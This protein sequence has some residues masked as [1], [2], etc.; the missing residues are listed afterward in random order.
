MLCNHL[1]FCK[2]VCKIEIFRFVQLRAA[3]LS[4]PFSLLLIFLKLRNPFLYLGLQQSLVGQIKLISRGIDVGILGEGQLHEGIVLLLAE[5][6]GDGGLLE[7]LLHE[8]VEIIDIHLHLPQ[9]LVRQ[10][11]YLQVN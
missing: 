8:A 5:Q 11:V 10:L 9:V 2:L 6:Y 3:Q 7:V 1:K 4:I